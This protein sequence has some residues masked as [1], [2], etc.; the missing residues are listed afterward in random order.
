MDGHK[1][2]GRAKPSCLEYLLPTAGRHGYRSRSSPAPCADTI[3]SCPAVSSSHSETCFPSASITLAPRMWC[4]EKAATTDLLVRSGI[5]TG[6]S[7][8][9]VLSKTITLIQELEL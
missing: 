3:T 5:R 8:F 1:R 6:V 9:S 7:Q 4:G 2:S